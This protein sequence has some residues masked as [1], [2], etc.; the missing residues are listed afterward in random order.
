MVDCVQTWRKK[1]R[2]QEL[3]DIAKNELES[4]TEISEI[5]EI[6]DK[7]MSF[8]WKLVNSTRKLYLEDVKKILANQFVLVM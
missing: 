6:L 4:G 2:L 7:A 1:L 8:R 5:Y 3:V